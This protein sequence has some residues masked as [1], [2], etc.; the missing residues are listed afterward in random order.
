M[1]W[2]P[3]IPSLHFPTCPDGQDTDGGKGE[4]NEKE[5]PERKKGGWSQGSKVR[6]CVCARTRLANLRVRMW[7][8]V[9][10]CGVRACVRG[11]VRVFVPLL[12]FK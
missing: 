9:R 3:T 4:V 6:A 12:C 5:R 11:C 1:R 2:G 7:A 10:A 8:C